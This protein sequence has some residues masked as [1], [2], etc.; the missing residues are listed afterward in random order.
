[1]KSVTILFCM[2]DNQ[3]APITRTLWFRFYAELNDF[4]PE[5]QR[6]ILFA[7]QFIGTPSVKDAIEAAGVPHPEI[8]LILVN[9]KSVDFD[10]RVYGGEQVSVY[11]V[12]ESFDITPLVRLRPAP[13]RQTKFIVDVNLGK[14][15]A[16]LRL[17]GFDTLYRNDFID[18]EIVEVSLREQRIILTRDK[19]LLKYRAATHGYWVR[20]DDPKRQLQEVV[21]R[22]QLKNG[23]HPFTRCSDCNALLQ[24]VDKALVK[25]RLPDDTWQSVEDFM[26][27][28]GCNKIYWRGSHYDRICKLIDDL[29]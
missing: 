13:L 1:M 22:L 9:G 19:G 26:L 21:Q 27:C 23:F 25:A 12:F 6:R 24:P 18:S 5:K 20:S 14:L 29:S 8:D 4:L 15:A 28:T 17:L 3:H 11:P 16:K 2:K 10:Q 7:W